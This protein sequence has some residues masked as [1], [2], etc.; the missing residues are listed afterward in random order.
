MKKSAVLL[1]LALSIFYTAHSRA[2]VW[3]ANNQWNM[4]YEEQF[5]QWIQTLPLDVFNNVNSKYYGIPTDCANA[6]Y[7]L[8]IAF[9]YEHSL[10]IQ[11]S[12][13]DL[14][15]SNSKFD[16]LS[17][18][19]IVDT[20]TS[21]TRISPRLRAFIDYVRNNTGTYSLPFDTYP[22]QINRQYVRPGLMFVHASSGDN[23]PLTYRSGHVYY[24]QDV[25]ENG[26]IK[27]I[28]ST[29]P[30]AVRPL[31]ARYGIVFAPQ[32]KGSGYRAWKWPNS[33]ERPG[34][35]EE[36]FTFANW[37]AAQYGNVTLWNNW[38]EA[39]QSRIRVRKITPEENFRA[40]DANLRAALQERVTA[41][42]EGWKYYSSNYASGQCVR[43]DDYESFSTSTRDVKIQQQLQD[44]EEHAKA[45]VQTLRRG[46]FKSSESRLKKIYSQFQ[47]QVL[48]EVTVNFLQLWDAFMTEKVL[49]ISE[50]EHAPLVRWGLKAQGRWP[51]PE[52]AKQYKGGE[53]VTPY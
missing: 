38:Q 11:F 19:E 52:R 5:S 9:A 40:A 48:P 18:Q 20:K 14:N 12:K 21:A 23:V 41:V 4:A 47:I 3:V 42:Q 29:V 22:V 17:D 45:Y 36:Q 2:S 26:M 46:F 25:A 50:P 28:G 39:I 43:G 33:N 35:S 6:V 53:L 8:R 7:T 27:Y 32:E 49:A 34:Y 24:L 10:P 1:I 16:S 31:A 15:N 37:K 30:R 13:A 51:C 44:Y